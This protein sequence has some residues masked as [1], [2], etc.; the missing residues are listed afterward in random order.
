M[1]LLATTNH[2]SNV[3]VNGGK[4]ESTFPLANCKLTGLDLNNI[5][6]CQLMDKKVHFYLSAFALLVD[7]IFYKLI[8]TTYDDM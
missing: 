4:L 2:V 5:L 6:F 7:N 8:E 3:N 1:P